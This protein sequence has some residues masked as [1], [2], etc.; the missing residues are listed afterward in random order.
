MID[1]SARGPARA[2]AAALLAAAVA[3]CATACGAPGNADPVRRGAGPAIPET[4]AG[5]PAVRDPGG[6]AANGSGEGS[7]AG[8][9][10]GPA[11]TAGA[12]GGDALIAT[13]RGASVP[14]FAEKGA[15]A[16]RRSLASPN[17]AGAPRVLLVRETA[18]AWLRVLL[19]VRPNG[20]TGWV[21]AA[22]VT[23]SRTAYRV[24]IDAK[25]FR[26]TV[27]HGGRAVRSGKVATGEG[28]TPTP[29]GL[30][31]LT[32]LVRPADRDGV[33]G[34]YAFGLSGFSPVLKSFAGGPGQLAI[35]GTNRSGA[36]GSRA[37]HGCVR[38]SNTDITWMAERL[39]L[40]T[41]VLIT[42]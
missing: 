8:S 22:D 4:G 9:G 41:P 12:R 16:P 24:E 15:A 29:G 14:V 28:G 42:T 32:E 19:P 33:Y 10:D 35:H 38:V 17:E 18:G 36:L 21:R 6:G 31:Y 25:G 27:R 1:R 37:S 13:A 11:G 26:F 23:L 39:P 30:F 20:S 2:V 3:A 7:A 34:A 40:G 5:G